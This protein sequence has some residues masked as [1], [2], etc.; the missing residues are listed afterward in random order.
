MATCPDKDQSGSERLRADVALLAETIG[1]RNTSCL[2]GLRRA[3]TFLME[4]FTSL[5]YQPQREEFTAD[6]MTVANI[7]VE[8]AGTGDG[9]EI[10]IIGAHYDSAPGTPGAN[11]NASGVAALL[12]IARQLRE[13][14]PKRTVRLVAFVNEEPPY[15]QTRQMGSWVH[16][17]LARQ[18]GE[19]II[20]MLCLECLGIY[21][22]LP[23]SQYYPPPLNHIYPDTGN[24]IAFCG[25]ITSA[26]LVRRCIMEFRAVTTFPSQWLVAPE[27]L[28]G[29]GWSD[30][31]S[32]WQE[33]YQ[34]VMITD[35]AFFRYGDYHTR[36]DT[37]DKLDYGRMATVVEGIGCVVRKL[38][39]GRW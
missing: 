9:A 19:R 23:G 1:E 7:V 30:H 12:E 5:G 15:F 20:A 17:T 27:H 16:A 24:F 32:F 31:W 28:P 37:V 26:L 29:I 33:G 18:R 2:D 10:V 35:T 22:D 36:E 6:G 3:E 39:G 4:R 21:S 38:V 13:G 14:R 8:L 34:A 11:D 25:N